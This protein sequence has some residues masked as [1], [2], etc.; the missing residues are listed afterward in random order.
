M[1]DFAADTLRF[2]ATSAPS[3]VSNKGKWYSKLVLGVAQ[4]FYMSDAGVEYQMAPL[5]AVPAGA[6]T[7]AKTETKITVVGTRTLAD[8]IAFQD[9][10][11][12]GSS[13]VSLATGVHYLRGFYGTS[14][15]TGAA[16]GIRSIFVQMVASAGLVGTPGVRVHGGVQT[17]Q[18]Q[19][20]GVEYSTAIRA[21]GTSY[22]VTPGPTGSRFSMHYFEGLIDVTTAGDMTPQ[23][24]FNALPGQLTNV[25]SQSYMEITRIGASSFVQ[26]GGWA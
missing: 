15:T 16:Y 6:V 19:A 23:I 13:K 20:N 12:S 5:A 2:I 24:Q 26:Q 3:A 14:P 17:L 11:A 7:I 21:F 8:S 1:T 10:F 25:D 22:Q 4:Q 18:T 9:M